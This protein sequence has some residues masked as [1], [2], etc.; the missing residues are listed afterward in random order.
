[1][2]IP[3]ISFGIRGFP[4]GQSLSSCVVPRLERLLN[5]VFPIPSGK[6]KIRC[7]HQRTKD[8]QGDERGSTVDIACGK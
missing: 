8:K 3:L 2:S 5:R 6:G 7:H 1:M 4:D